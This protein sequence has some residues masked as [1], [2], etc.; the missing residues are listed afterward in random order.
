MDAVI[1]VLSLLLFPIIDQ[2]SITINEVTTIVL[3]IPQEPGYNGQDF[4]VSAVSST[5]LKPWSAKADEDWL[6]KKPSGKSWY[7]AI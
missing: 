6:D 7:L 2:L 4:Q 3:A 1:G 5:E